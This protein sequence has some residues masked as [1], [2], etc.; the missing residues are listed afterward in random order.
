MD[1]LRLHGMRIVV[2]PTVVLP[3]VRGIEDHVTWCSDEVRVEFNNWLLTR[4]GVQASCV[5]HPG[6]AV[7]IKEEG[8]I[9]V[10]PSDYVQIKVGK[11]QPC[12]RGYTLR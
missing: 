1:Q 2:A 10:H 9:L 6:S 3:I 8:I 5:V 12:S 4:F 7:A 11:T